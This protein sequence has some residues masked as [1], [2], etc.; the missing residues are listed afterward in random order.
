MSKL[1]F[2]VPAELF[3]KSKSAGWVRSSIKY[4]R[5]ESLSSAVNFA[6]DEYGANLNGISIQTNTDEYTGSAIRSLYENEQYP[7]RGRRAVQQRSPKAA[8]SA[9]GPAASASHKFKIGDAVRYLRPGLVGQSG[10]YEIVKV[11][12]VENAGPAYRIKNK[13]EQHEH[14][15]KEHEIAPV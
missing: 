10:Y 12:P 8:N 1:D 3:V 5:F 11:L 4:R 15:V 14:A 13:S 6:M 9:S 7:L 2:F